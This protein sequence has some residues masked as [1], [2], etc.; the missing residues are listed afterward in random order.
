MKKGFTLIE[1]LVVVLI[2]GILAAISLPQ[3]TKA[4]E[5]SRLA[6]ANIVMKNIY[7]SLVRC[8]LANGSL[9]GEGVCFWDELDIDLA[10]PEADGTLARQSKNFWYSLETRGHELF[11]CRGQF[12]QTAE[13]DYCLNWTYEDGHP[14]QDLKRVCEARTDKGKSVCASVGKLESDDNYVY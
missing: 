4:V 13:Y 6:E 3:Y 7:D 14:D 1:L 10:L 8:S 11:A 12:D 2:I 9:E 5:K